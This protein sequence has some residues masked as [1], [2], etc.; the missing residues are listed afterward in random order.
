MH[1]FVSYF[2]PLTSNISELQ[3][4]FERICRIFKGCLRSHFKSRGKFIILVNVRIDN[5]SKFIVSATGNDHSTD[6]SFS[7]ISPSMSSKIISLFK[8]T[9]VASYMAPIEIH[10]MRLTAFLHTST[11]LVHR[12]Y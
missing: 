8:S 2:L 10:T 5:P 11:P 9:I 7:S 4:F 6:K 1:L 3:E 12:P